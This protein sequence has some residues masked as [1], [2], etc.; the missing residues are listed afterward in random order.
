MKLTL[1]DVAD[2]LINLIILGASF[3]IAAMG[4]QSILSQVGEDGG[5]PKMKMRIFH[6]LGAVILAAS[7]FSI[8]KLILSYLPKL[9]IG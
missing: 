6:I 1:G 5:A 7:A 8:K 3:R 4:L 2:A 9:F